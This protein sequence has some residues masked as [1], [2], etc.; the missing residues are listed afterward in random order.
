MCCFP[1]GGGA[2][3]VFLPVRSLTSSAAKYGAPA[4]Q[5]HPAS[6]ADLAFQIHNLG[7]QQ[8]TNP[9]VVQQIHSPGLHWVFVCLVVSSG[10]VRE[11]SNV[12]RYFVAGFNFSV[13]LNQKS[14]RHINN[15]IHNWSTTV[16]TRRREILIIFFNRASV[17]RAS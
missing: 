3:D 10:S 9:C 4:R 6:Q 8:R 17:E 16:T 12:S 7:F 11:L 13:W 14:Q 5:S 1:P 2:C 15:V